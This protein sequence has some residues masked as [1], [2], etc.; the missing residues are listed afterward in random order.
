MENLRLSE[1]FT[2]NEF[3]RSSTATARGI[4]N[5]PT[6]KVIDNL[7]ALCKYVLQPLRNHYGKALTISSGYR[8]KALN[9]AVGGSK[10]SQH[11]TGEAADIHLPNMED[12][13]KLFEFIRLC[14]PFDQLIWEHDK[15]G[16]YWIHVSFK[17]NMKNNRH[18]VINDLLKK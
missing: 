2:L 13:R 15:R 18:Q 10:T 3:L 12:G 9:T 6:Q 7:T 14:L 4:K 8:C 11:M 1:N 5:E 17:A 16:V